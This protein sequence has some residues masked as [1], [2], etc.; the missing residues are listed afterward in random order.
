MLLMPAMTSCRFVPWIAGLRLAS[1]MCTHRRWALAFNVG[2]DAV[3]DPG[4]A[5]HKPGDSDPINAHAVS[6]GEPNVRYISALCGFATVVFVNCLD[7]AEHR[8]ARVQHA[9]PG[10]ECLRR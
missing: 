9:I 5:H 1:A 7:A 8:E 4:D 3:A 6:R 10:D 2:E